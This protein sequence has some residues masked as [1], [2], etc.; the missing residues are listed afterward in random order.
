LS[1]SFSV[2]LSFTLFSKF[3]DELFVCVNIGPRRDRYPEGVIMVVKGEESRSKDNLV[4][5]I[6]NGNQKLSK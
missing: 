3:F 5:K 2:Y 6:Y 4:R 1:L